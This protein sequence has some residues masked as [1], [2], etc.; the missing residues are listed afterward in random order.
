MEKHMDYN[1]TFKP[2]EQRPLK[3]CFLGVV[4][5]S[6]FQLTQSQTDFEAIINKDYYS[7]I[8]YLEYWKW[9][10]T[11]FFNVGLLLLGIIV[12]KV[13][14]NFANGRPGLAGF[15][16]PPLDPQLSSSMAVFPWDAL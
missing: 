13:A 6:T 8:S 14:T 3:W 1:I 10:S 7:G 5:T 2:E 12:A 9:R 15:R 11:V 4:L 16:V